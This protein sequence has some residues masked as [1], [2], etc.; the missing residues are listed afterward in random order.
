VMFMF[1]ANQVFMYR[2]HA[3]YKL[4]LASVRAFRMNFCHLDRTS[5]GSSYND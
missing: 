3:R 4:C 1:L 2:A 5:E